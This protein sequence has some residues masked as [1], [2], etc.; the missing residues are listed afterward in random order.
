MEPD[1]TMFD[2]FMGRSLIYWRELEDKLK[3][4]ESINTL[5]MFEE[6]VSLKEKNIVLMERLKSIRKFVEYSIQN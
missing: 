1:M 4:S 5:A 3:S 6:L 2:T